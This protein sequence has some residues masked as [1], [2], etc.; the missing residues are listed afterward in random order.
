MS[1]SFW[2]KQPIDSPR[3]R[4]IERLGADNWLYHVRVASLDELDAEVQDW[5]CR[6][7]EVGCQPV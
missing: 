1:L 3:F 2:L 7:Y 6:S 5:L 4:R